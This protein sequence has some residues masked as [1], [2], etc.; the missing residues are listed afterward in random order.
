MKI[1]NKTELLEFIRIEGLKLLKLE[2]FST[3]ENTDTLEDRISDV[4]AGF[5]EVNEKRLEKLQREEEAAVDKEEY[6][7]LQ[8]IKEEKF[9]VLGKLIA[10]Q[11]KKIEYLEKIKNSLGKELE[12]MG[13]QGSGV[14][15]NKP[16]IELNNEELP[17]GSK[18][19]IN[20]ISSELTLEKISEGNQFNVLKSNATGIIS[21]DIISLPVAIKIGSPA[22]ITVYRKMGAPGSERFEEIGRPEIKNITQILKNPA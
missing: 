4:D 2:A 1:K 16:I 21:G 18:I 13:V 10:A 15:K 19:K 12:E 9:N 22:Q 20:T 17:K 14:F 11:K 3:L 5:I 6:S 8:R 7:D